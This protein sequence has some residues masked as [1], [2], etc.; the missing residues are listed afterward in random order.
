MRGLTG[1]GKCERGERE[2][3]ARVRDSLA[4]RGADLRLKADRRSQGF[5]LISLRDMEVRSQESGVRSQNGGGVRAEKLADFL[6]RSRD[7]FAL[8]CLRDMEVRSQESEA[9]MAVV[10][11]QRSLLTSSNAAETA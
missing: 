6:Q 4:G 7:G 3:R 10:Y 5:A 8:I 1:W 11:A 9:R 2:R